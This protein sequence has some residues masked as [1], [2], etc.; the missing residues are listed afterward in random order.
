MRRRRGTRRKRRRVRRNKEEEEEFVLFDFESVSDTA[1]PDFHEYVKLTI[2]LS[3][4][5]VDREAIIVNQ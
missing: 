3:G 4:L 2:A 5:N 1:G